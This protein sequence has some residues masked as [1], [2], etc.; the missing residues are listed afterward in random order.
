MNTV[1]IMAVQRSAGKGGLGGG[2]VVLTLM[3]EA[4][5]WITTL[6]EGYSSA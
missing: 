5:W 2:S 1:F 3:K 4:M 6:E